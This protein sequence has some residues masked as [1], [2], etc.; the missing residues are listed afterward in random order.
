MGGDYDYDADPLNSQYPQDN[1]I[2]EEEVSG[3]VQKFV[4]EESEKKT[5]RDCYGAR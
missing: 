5:F 1:Y 2:Y 3:Q 4:F